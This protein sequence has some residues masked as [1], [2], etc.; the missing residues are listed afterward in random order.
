MVS[1]DANSDRRPCPSPV[2]TNLGSNKA[3]CAGGIAPSRVG[4]VLMRGEEPAGG[5]RPVDDRAIRS[6]GADQVLAGGDHRVHRQVG[7][8]IA[9]APRGGGHYRALAPV[10]GG[11]ECPLVGVRIFANRAPPGAL[12]LRQR[13]A[14]AFGLRDG[15]RPHS[16][17]DGPTAAIRTAREQ[18]FNGTTWACF[19]EYPDRRE[20]RVTTR[21]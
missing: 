21:Y 18:P 7:G 1:N 6:T 13:S 4:L 11:R 14:S 12:Q 10:K 2:R 20:R 9:S 17:E 3:D 15:R 19:V 5:T 8:G 16:A